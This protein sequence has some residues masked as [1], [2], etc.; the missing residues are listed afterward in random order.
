MQNGAEE[1]GG[2]LYGPLIRDMVWSYSRIKAFE[3]CPYRWFLNY[4]EHRRETDQFYS[5]FGSYMHSLMA[6]FY[7]GKAEPDELAARFLSGFRENVKGIRPSPELAAKY[8]EAGAG[9]L[10][11][12][13]MPAEEIVGVEKQI[14]FALDSIPFTGFIDLLTRTDE[15]LIITDHKSRTLKPRTGKNPPTKGDREIDDM[16]RQLYLYSASVRD[17]YGVF[18]A[19]LR[20]NCFRNGV[21]IEEPFREEAYEEAVRWAVDSVGKIMETEDF[22]PMPDYFACRWLCGFRDWCGEG[23]SD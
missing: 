4:I 17:E 6:E 9:F 12:L 7:E 15:G 8:I 5:S 23:E 11:G 22:A 21:L 13:T 3:A 20:F 10:R 18:P 14:F 2:M 16:L 1:K 19:K